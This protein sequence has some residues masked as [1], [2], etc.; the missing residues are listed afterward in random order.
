[1]IGYNDTKYINK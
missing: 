1:M